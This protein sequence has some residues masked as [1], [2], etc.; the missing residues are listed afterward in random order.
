MRLAVPDRFGPLERVVVGVRADLRGHGVDH[1]P[2]GERVTVPAEMRLQIDRR[3]RHAGADDEPVARL[4]Q[5]REVGRGQHPGVGDHDQVLDAVPG[6]ERLDDRQQRVLLR[7]VPFETADLQREPGPVDQ[8]PD[9]DL[10][11]DPAFLGVA[12]LAQ[13]IFVVGL[14]VQRRHVI[15]HQGDVAVRG[16]VGEAQPGQLVAVLAVGAAAQ[17]AFAGGQAHR[18]AAQLGQDPVDVGQAGRLDHPGDHQIPEHLIAQQRRTRGSSR[19]R[20]ARR[21]TP[22][23]PS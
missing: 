5:C 13:L 15:E 16:G 1:L 10:R 3:L 17:R 2:V 7:L 9:H 21:T 14:E 12:D 6:L 8:Q 19:R 23:R 20:P 18:A 11:I 4:V 22:P